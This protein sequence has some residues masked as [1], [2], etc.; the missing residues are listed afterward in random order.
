MIDHNNSSELPADAVIVG[1][2]WA[3]DEHVLCLIEPDGRSNI[4]TLEQSPAAI[5]EWAD[6]RASRRPLW[7]SDRCRRFGPGSLR[8]ILAYNR[9][10]G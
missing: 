4:D 6:V 2:D 3:D 10:C 5:D 8:V 7:T 9:P 1:I